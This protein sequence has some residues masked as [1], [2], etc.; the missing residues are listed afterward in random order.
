MDHGKKVATILS[1]LLSPTAVGF[2]V[3][4]LLLFFSMKSTLSVDVI[5]TL[6]SAI[7]FLCIL[8]I[9]GILVYA[10]KGR[11]DI[12]VS[13]RKTRTPFYALAIGSYIFGVCWFYY[14]NLY[15]LFVLSLTY[16]F[17]TTIIAIINLKTKISS[18]CAGLTGPFTAMIFVF[19]FIAIPLFCLLPP[20]IWARLKLNAHTHLQLI[21][22]SFIG[23]IVTG[24]IYFIVY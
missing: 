10:R 15:E 5:L 17:V 11:I 3:I 22:G 8:P 21:T 18:H 13:N 20:I 4:L 16:V 24:A 12:W 6:I 14:M 7:F 2:Y 19:G 1:Y 23:V 9:I